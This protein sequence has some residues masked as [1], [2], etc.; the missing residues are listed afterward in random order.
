MTIEELNNRINKAQVQLYHDCLQM[1]GYEV[2][3]YINAETLYKIKQESNIFL[4]PYD[5]WTEGFYKGCKFCITDGT[6]RVLV[7]KEI[8]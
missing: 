8:V 4:R 6:E 2:M 1:A 3:I 7:S 5:N